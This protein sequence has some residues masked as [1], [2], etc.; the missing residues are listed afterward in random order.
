[1]DAAEATPRLRAHDDEVATE[2]G[3][4]LLVG[5]LGLAVSL[6]DLA[7][8]LAQVDEQLDVECGVDEPGL[9]EWTG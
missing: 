5:E 8:R 6:E 1:M 9:G 3:F 2:N 7:E 4:E